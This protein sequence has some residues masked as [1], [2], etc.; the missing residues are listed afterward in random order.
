ME[1]HLSWL[2]NRDKKPMRIDDQ[3]PFQALSSLTNSDTYSELH[4]I[5]NILC[6]HRVE[7]QNMHIKGA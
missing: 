6:K 4:I 2:A 3:K 5:F 7:H 1:N